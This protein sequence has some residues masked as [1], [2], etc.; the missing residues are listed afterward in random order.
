MLTSDNKIIVLDVV[1]EKQDDEFIYATKEEFKKLKQSRV[2]DYNIDVF[3]S[4]Y[5]G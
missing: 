5:R 4:F 2:V 3:N 1:E